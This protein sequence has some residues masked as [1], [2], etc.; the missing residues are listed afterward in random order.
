MEH[1]SKPVCK[2]ESPPCSEKEKNQ[3]NSLNFT[4]KIILQYAD[5]SSIGNA[6]V[7]CLSHLP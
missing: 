1:S 6:S 4:V 7:R 3:W 5:R 2:Q